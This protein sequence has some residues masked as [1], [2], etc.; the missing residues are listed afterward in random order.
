MIDG[1]SERSTVI[2]VRAHDIPGLL[3]AVATVLTTLGVSVVS[4]RVQ[5]L[6][7]DAVDVF[8]LQTA[9]GTPLSPARARASPP[10]SATPWLNP[11]HHLLTTHLGRA[12]VDRCGR[13]RVRDPSAACHRLLE[14]TRPGSAVPGGQRRDRPRI[15]PAGPDQKA[16]HPPC[17]AGTAVPA[18]WNSRRRVDRQHR[19]SFTTI[20]WVTSAAG[21]TAGPTPNG[22]VHTAAVPPLG[23][24]M[25]PSHGWE[26]NHAAVR[27]RTTPARAD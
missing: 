9:A 10:R 8:Y 1:A 22:S 3:Y 16:T 27:G 21:D 19:S 25:E 23:R 7:A 11:R 5:T 14:S 4:A 6:G 13:P 12:P 2:E 15:R 24:S 26:K 17:R 18:A 20:R